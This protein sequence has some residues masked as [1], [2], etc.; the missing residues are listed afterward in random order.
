MGIFGE[1]LGLFFLIQ[2][3]KGGVCR[4]CSHLVGIV[5]WKVW[6]VVM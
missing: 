4:Y 1:S 5:K 3:K 6:D 2:E